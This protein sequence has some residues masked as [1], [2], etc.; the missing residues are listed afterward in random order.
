MGQKLRAVMGDGY[1]AYSKIKKVKTR[2]LPH[3]IFR[4]AVPFSRTFSLIKKIDNQ[5]SIINS[6]QMGR[7]CG[8]PSCGARYRWRGARGI[9]IRSGPV[10]QEL[11]S[12]E[13]ENVWQ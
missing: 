4:A 3:G 13:E 6:S 12:A 11:A 7:K 5:R 2:G 9:G 10:R 1:G 8:I